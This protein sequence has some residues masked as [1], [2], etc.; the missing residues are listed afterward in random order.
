[1]KSIKEVADKLVGEFTLSEEWLTAGAVSSALR[2]VDGNV[3]SGV[4]LDLACGIGFCAE[5]SAIAEMIKNRETR[6]AEIVAV[7]NKGIIP[8]CGRCLELIFQ[9][10]ASNINTKVLLPGDRVALLKELLPDHWI[11]AFS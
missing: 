5:H 2:T 7:N 10:D 11:E 3:Y 4:C 1:M 9:V 8:P 6:I